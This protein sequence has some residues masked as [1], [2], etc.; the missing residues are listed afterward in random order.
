MAQLL[1]TVGG[2]SPTRRKKQRQKKVTG[3]PAP[4]P[5][6]IED[7]AAEV[8]IP[9]GVSGVAG[10]A[11]VINTKA[12][13]DA[14]KPKV[15]PRAPSDYL[16]STIDMFTDRDRYAKSRLFLDRGGAGFNLKNKDTQKL[17]NAG[18]LSYAKNPNTGLRETVLSGSP[19]A[20]ERLLDDNYKIKTNKKGNIVTQRKSNDLKITDSFKILSAGSTAA[21]D[22]NQ[23]V[24]RDPRL[25]WD[26]FTDLPNKKIK[27]PVTGKEIKF[28][29]RAEQA[30][31]FANDKETEKRFSERWQKHVAEEGG[32]AQLSNLLEIYNDPK[33]TSEELESAINAIRPYLYS[34]TSTYKNAQEGFLNSLRGSNTFERSQELTNEKRIAED[35]AREDQRIVD[36]YGSSEAFEKAK[37]QAVTTFSQATNNQQKLQWLQEYL[38][39]GRGELV[40]GFVTRDLL[41]LNYTRVN[42]PSAPGGFRYVKSGG[43]LESAADVNALVDTLNTLVEQG[44]PLPFDQNQLNSIADAARKQEKIAQWEYDNTGQQPANPW[45]VRLPDPFGALGRFGKDVQDEVMDPNTTIG[46]WLAPTTVEKGEL[47]TF[48]TLTGN[49]V[50]G[51]ARGGAGFPFGVYMLSTNPAGTVSAAIEDYKSRYNVTD[52]DAVGKQFAEDPSAYVFD[53]LGLVPFAGWSVKTGQILSNASKVAR[54][55]AAGSKVGLFEYSKL[56]RNAAS[57]NIGAKLVLEEVLNDGT[58]GSNS[59]FNPTQMDKA[60]GLFEPRY[61]IVSRSAGTRQGVS[62]QVAGL[63]ATPEDATIRI[64]YSGNPLSRGIQKNYFRLQ[65]GI[66]KAVTS[67]E[68]RTGKALTA[69]QNATGVNA[70]LDWLTEV[71]GLGFDFRYNRAR[72]MGEYGTNELMAR[73]IYLAK[74]YNKMIEDYGFID[75][76]NQVIADIVTGGAY[77]PGIYRSLYERSLQEAA[78]A[79]RKLES[80]ELMQMSEA[81]LKKLDSPEWQAEY[82]RI[83]EDSM[84]EV[85]ET[86]RGKEMQKAS[87]MLITL[88][89]KNNRA[90]TGTITPEELG[91]YFN[92]YAPITRALRLDD[93]DITRELGDNLE[94]VAVFNPN[95]HFNELFEEYP[96]DLILDDNGQLVLHPDAKNVNKLIAQSLELLRTDKST[97]NLGGHPVFVVDEIL[98]M[99]DGFEVVRG[100]RLVMEGDWDHTTGA[101]SRKGLLDSTPIYLPKS[102]FVP[103]KQGGIQRLGR[104]EALSQARVA[105]L[106]T[107]VKAFPNV[108]DF[109]DK[110]SDINVNGPESFSSRKTRNEVIAA[111]LHDY[112]LKIQLDATVASIK[113]RYGE[114]MKEQVLGAAFPVSM[115]EF[116]PKVHKALGF[117]EIF[118]SYDEAAAYS[119]YVDEAGKIQE[120][121]IEEVT[122]DGK[123]RFIIDRKFFDSNAAA[124]REQRTHRLDD[125]RLEAEKTFFTDLKNI[126][127]RGNPDDQYIMVIPK[128]DYLALDRSVK[129]ANKFAQVMLE[130]GNNLSSI[131]KILTLSLNPRFLSQNVFGGTIMLMMA[132]PE[133]AAQTMASM[134]SYSA[135]RATGKVGKAEEFASHVDDLNFFNRLFPTDFGQY[136]IYAQDRLQGVLGR[137]GD[138]TL[139]KYTI[140]NG[141]TTVQAFEATMRTS[142]MRQASLSYP[143]FKTLMNSEAAKVRALMGDPDWG[144]ETISPFQAAVKIMSERDPNFLFEI[145]HAADSVVGNYRNF[146]DFER[147]VRN[148]LLPFYAWQRHSAMFTKRL[149]QERPLTANVAYNIGNYGYEQ[150][151][152]GGGVPE[153]LMGKVPMPSAI[154]RIF[155]EEEGYQNLI[156]LD[157]LNPFATTADA[158]KYIGGSLFEGSIVPRGGIFDYTNPFINAAVEKATGTSLLT[159]APIGADRK[160]QTLFKDMLDTFKSFPAIGLIMKAFDDDI[161]LNEERGGATPDSI[162]DDPN[163]PSKGITIPGDKLSKQYSTLSGAGIFNALSPVK[164]YQIN[165]KGSAEAFKQEMRDRGIEVP[166]TSIKITD[167]YSRTFNAIRNYERK[168]KFVYEVWWPR[169]SEQY[170]ELAQKI[171]QALEADQPN[172]PKNFPRSMYDAAINGG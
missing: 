172:V 163:D 115:S 30:R 108:R 132:R 5:N 168:R 63:E 37:T 58:D 89:E 49:F 113:A 99:G 69:I 122:I 23:A 116:N 24:Y 144:L 93:V 102:A 35:K 111:A 133:W 59:L 54:L 128:N 129:R 64:R 31:V 151:M 79:G 17:I 74:A 119:S 109:T 87:R 101:A 98:D 40:P 80:D 52:P 94:N 154:S 164:G 14:L 34:P 156:G 42:D 96:D 73:D 169:Y 152:A 66:S 105:T 55:S 11:P 10:S 160:N 123:T 125:A 159:G 43:A 56:A 86:E 167:S 84:R 148:Y 100:R 110:I 117:K 60:A 68:S 171:L 146:S 135:R 20:V 3:R 48:G 72:S 130:G 124:L 13:L 22:A 12:N 149:V 57:G 21:F 62:D 158:T 127:R 41:G 88:L 112:N 75:I 145:R 95:R 76:E 67:P 97:R 166:D 71:P 157:A 139:G 136:N 6:R 142:I 27:D 70:R 16:F 162:L 1:D 53:A 106:N 90:L 92:A 103:S 121:P 161:A 7:N 104:E 38:T 45:N 28:P 143:G 77:S 131:F 32:S 61:E 147:T 141:Y 82:A 39:T 153:W 138:S 78:A 36:T 51:L 50:K 8:N 118:D 33:H 91:L 165:S 9:S 150:V 15:E 83:R 26:Q 107:L 44:T 137:V 4:R 81:Y 126:Q 25:L 19:Q 65:T 120:N 114:R 170:P 134:I 46:G 140:Y 47:P 85:P 155:G 18:L 29:D 2:G